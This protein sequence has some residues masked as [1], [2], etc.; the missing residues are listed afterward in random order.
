[1]V[2]FKH[3]LSLFTW[4]SKLYVPV[5]SK[6]SPPPPRAYPRHLTGVLFHTVGNLTQN[7]PPPPPTQVRHLTFMPKHWSASQAK[8]FSLFWLCLVGYLHL[9]KQ[10]D[11]WENFWIVGEGFDTFWSTSW[12]V[13]GLLIWPSKLPKYQGISPKFWQKSQMP[14]GGGCLGWGVSWAV[15]V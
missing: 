15:L 5:N 11:A 7:V 2:N 4:V 8:G 14:G 9:N 12:Y 3:Y 6:L 13:W 1:M 10:F